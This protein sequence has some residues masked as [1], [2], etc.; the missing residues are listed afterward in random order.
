[1]K[2]DINFKLSALHVRTLVFRKSGLIK[3]Y[4]ISMQNVMGLRWLVQVLH[5]PQKFSRLPIWNGWSYGIKNDG[6]KVTFVG[7]MSLRN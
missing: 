1:M 6:F 4:S 5:P 3:S 7:M 2:Q